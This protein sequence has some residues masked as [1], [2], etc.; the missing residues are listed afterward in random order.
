MKRLLPFFAAL[1]CIGASL[2]ANAGSAGAQYQVQQPKGP[3]QT[4]GQIQQ[5]KGPW[6]VPKG[7]QAIKTTT[8]PCG[9]KYTVGAD[10][11]FAFDKYSL[12]PDAVQTLSVL[13]PIL[14]KA[15]NQPI[16]IAGYTD[17][18]G[19]VEY[20]VMLSR[21]RA[22]AVRDWLAAHGYVPAST[23]DVGYGK[24]DPIAPN[25]NSDGSDNPAGRQKNR[26]VEITVGNCH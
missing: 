16:R 7:I 20:N 19:S 13:G 21:E 14:K 25:T 12:S 9:K 18:V 26:R 4:P 17:S 1:V 22:K 5:P 15:A 6:Q 2:A 8:Q 11:L 23:P 3:W 24:A 10:A